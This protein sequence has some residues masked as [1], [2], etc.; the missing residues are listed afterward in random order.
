M[1]FSN[2]VK[3]S[4]FMSDMGYYTNINEV[5]AQYFTENP[6]ARE[7]VAVKTLPKNVNVEMSVI[8]VR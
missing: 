3:V 5:Y 2:V 6:P 7:A 4:I 1:S 8:A